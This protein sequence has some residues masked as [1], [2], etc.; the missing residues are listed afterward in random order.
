MP[1]N[2]GGPGPRG[3]ASGRT[4]TV[5]SRKGGPWGNPG[6][7]SRWEPGGKPGDERPESDRGPR[8]PNNPFGG[9]P[10]GGGGGGG[11][12]GGGGGPFGGGGPGGG[13]DID[14]LIEQAQAFIRRTFGGGGGRRRSRRTVGRRRIRPCGPGGFSLATF[15][16]S[17]S[18]AFLGLFVVLIWV[19]SGFY[20]VQPDEQ[21]VVLRF[22][23]YSYWTPPG[24]HWHLPWPIETVM[25]PTVTR[26]N[27][28]EIGFRS[29]AGA[30][31]G[32]WARRRRPER[33]GGKPDADRRREHHRH[34]RRQSSGASPMPPTSCSTPPTPRRWCGR[35]PKARCAR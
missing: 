5:R 31:D 18:L 2:N 32:K 8:R 4:M 12:F 13:S 22:G 35:W 25:L 34:R 11:P 29:G 16:S 10:F 28:T 33:A 9:G 15:T 19:G 24:L 1:W 7:Q 6:G 14:R 17:R 3:N 27:R 21:G 26:I 23:A 30:T 20:R